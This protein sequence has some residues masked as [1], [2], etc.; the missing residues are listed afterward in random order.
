MRRERELAQAYLGRK[1]T[2]RE[3]LEQALRGGASLSLLGLLVAC[4]TAPEAAAPEATVPS[5]AVEASLGAAPSAA[6]S[7][8]AASAAP[9]TGPVAGGTLRMAYSQVVSDTLNQHV[10]NH[11]QSRMIARHV[12]DCLVAVDP[13]TGEI[14]PWLATEWE[15]SDDSTEYTFK[16]REGVTFHDGT[17]FNAEAVKAN[18]EFTMDP[19]TKHGFA[20]GALGGDKFKGTEVVDE[21]TVKL[22]YNE[23]YGTLLPSLSDGGTGIDSPTALTAGGENYGITSLVGTGPYRFVEWVAK[24]RVVLEP[25]PDYAWGSAVNGHE[26]PPFL[27]QLIFQ[28]IAENATRA[29][30]LQNGDIQ[31]SQ[32]VESQA[33]EF[34]GSTDVAIQLVPKPGTSRMYVMNMKRPALADLRVRQAINHAVDKPTLIRLPAWAGIG[35]PGVAPLPANMVPNGDLSTLQ[36]F[37]YAFDPERA[38]ALLDEAGWTVGADGIREKDGKQLVLE[39]VTTAASVPTVEPVDGMLNAV[40]IKLNINSGDFN[41]YIETT[42]R[43]EF[44]I[45]QRS[46][47]GYNAVGM[48]EEYFHTTGVYNTHGMET[49][50]EAAEIDAAIDKALTTP[51]VET[52]WEGLFTAMELVMKNAVAIMGWEIDYVFGVRSSVQDVTFNEVGYPYFVDVNLAG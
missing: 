8:V 18:F 29:A 2:R 7:T 45:T 28:E 10:S 27:E 39:V 17:P 50:P 32:L 14:V 15:V 46:D 26:G 21:Y 43:G 25:N 30:A 31:M 34:E 48:I 20:Y 23:P 1:I 4:G 41:Y 16:L 5:T 40:G 13:E 42:A 22:T 36:P 19:N 24:D 47:S 6:T 38:K 44:D 51:D 37:D 9:S 11:T 49:L 12:L 52:R 33:A 35:R 3:M